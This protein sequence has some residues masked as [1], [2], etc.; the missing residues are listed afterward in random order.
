VNFTHYS[1]D[2]A[3]LGADLVNTR[4][5]PSGREYLGDAETLREFLVEHEMQV[6]PRITDADIEDVHRWR[7]RLTAVWEIE[8]EGSKAE[9]LNQILREVDA[10]PQLTDHDGS[11][12]VHYVC[13]DAPIS[14]KIAGAAAMG[15]A[16]VLSE[17]GVTRFGMCGAEDCLDVFVDTSRNKSRRYCGDTCSTR[18]NV[19]AY[20]KRKKESTQA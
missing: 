18:V 9:I 6:P 3:Q 20:R 7:D 15:L 5:R 10:L 17:Y 19:A 14:H 12:H 11:W 8:G 13:S 2:A 1:E 4:G 16:N